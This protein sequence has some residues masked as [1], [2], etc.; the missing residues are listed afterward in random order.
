M[1]YLPSREV[2]DAAVCDEPHGRTVPSANPVRRGLSGD[3]GRRTVGTGPARLRNNPQSDYALSL[4]VLIWP[5]SYF[6]GARY[7]IRISRA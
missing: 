3:I 1:N 5:G 4:I 6:P 7:F 2:I